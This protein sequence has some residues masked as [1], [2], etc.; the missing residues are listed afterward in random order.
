MALPANP[1]L[2]E[3]A[4]GAERGR[5]IDSLGPP[6]MGNGPADGGAN[7]APGHGNQA[8][9]PWGNGSGPGAPGFGGVAGGSGGFLVQPD[10]RNEKPAYP[11]LARRQGLEGRVWLSLFVR[12]DGSVG[13]VRVT[14]S[15]GH[16][17]LDRAAVTSAHGWRFHYREELA[18]H[19]GAWVTLPIDFSL[20]AE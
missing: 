12:P 4:R 17:S 19:P 15:S 7:A 9:G 18:A 13:T 16:P 14:Q 1:A 3:V 20:Y 6:A 10:S 11:L 5:G 2:P 8:G